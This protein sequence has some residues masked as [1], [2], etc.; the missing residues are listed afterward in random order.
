M[1]KLDELADITR[2]A[3]QLQEEEQQAT[4]TND[5]VKVNKLQEK[6]SELMRR[7]DRSKSGG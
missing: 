7:R 1:D 6:I 2:Q 5:L 4:A 3:K